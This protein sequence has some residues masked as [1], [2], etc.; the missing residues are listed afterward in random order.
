MTNTDHGAQPSADTEIAERI[1][2]ALI[3][4]NIK[5]LA[6][7]EETGIAYPTLR[8]SLKGGR[9]LTFAEFA[10]IAAAIG[11]QPSALLP[12]SLTSRA[13]A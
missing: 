6:L 2:N 10:K 7:S 1:T 12:D 8:R 3:V 4:K 13:A 9:S 11:V 5:V